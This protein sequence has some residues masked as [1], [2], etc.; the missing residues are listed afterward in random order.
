MEFKLPRKERKRQKKKEKNL[1]KREREN[2]KDKK[3]SDKT[4][5]KEEKKEKSETD[6]RFFLKGYCQFGFQGKTPR[7][8]KD[9]CEYRHPKACPKLMNHGEGAGGC[10]SSSECNLAHPRMCK[11]PVSKGTCKFIG[12][13]SKCTR[14]FHVRGTKAPVNIV[15]APTST[16][17]PKS[18]S[19][20]TVTSGNIMENKKMIFWPIYN[21]I[22]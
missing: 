5:K 15:E 2:R 6:C 8:G 12:T 21:A 4:R 22:C 11:E 13:D 14:G 1:Q 10:K 18:D 9:G 7:N 16:D 17:Q 19:Q 20:T 3:K